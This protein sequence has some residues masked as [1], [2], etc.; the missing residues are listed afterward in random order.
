MLEIKTDFHLH[1]RDDRFDAIKHSAKE[2]IDAASGKGFKALA[3]TNHD[4]YTFN[5]ELRHYAADKG[6]LLIPGIEKTIQRKHVLLLNATPAAE[7][8]KSFSDLYRAKRDGLFIIAPHPFYKMHT[9]LDDKL[10]QNIELF[11]AIEFSYFY[12]KWFDLNRKAVKVAKKYNLPLVGNSDCHIIDHF[13]ICSSK[14]LAD[15]LDTESIFDSIKKHKIKV[16]SKPSH[17]YDLGRIIVK[18]EFAYLGFK[19]GRLCQDVGLTQN[20]IVL[21]N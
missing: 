18:M 19:L 16:V 15:R 6:I 14:V 1:T 13:G 11:D 2:L 4:T 9:C 21:N 17:L 5:Q 7:K 3:I 12:S 10:L 20:E 8:I